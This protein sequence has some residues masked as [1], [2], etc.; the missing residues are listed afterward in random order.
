MHDLRELQV[1]NGI[2]FKPHI[3]HIYQEICLELKRESLAINL[4]LTFEGLGQF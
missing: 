1:S 2:I 3:S 4:L